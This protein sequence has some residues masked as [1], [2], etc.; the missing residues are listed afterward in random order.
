MK[1]MGMLLIPLLVLALLAGSVG[2]GGEE[3]TPTPVPTAAPTA[4]PTATPTPPPIELRVSFAYAESDVRYTTLTKI[5]DLMEEYTDGRVK[6][7]LFTNAVLFPPATEWE[8][9][10]T[11]AVD[12]SF[13]A[14]YYASTVDPANMLWYLGGGV[15]ESPEHGWAV[16]EDGR[17]TQIFADKALANGVK[18]LGI[19]PYSMRQPF[20]CTEEVIY[21]KDAAG[22]KFA[23]GGAPSPIFQYMEVVPVVMDPSEYYV[24][25]AQGTVDS[26]GPSAISMV[27][28]Q[29]LYEVADY[30]FVHPMGYFAISLWMS[31]DTWNGLPADIQ[32]IIENKVVPEALK[33]SHDYFV[34]QEEKDMAELASHLVALHETQ[35]ADA[36]A[37]AEALETNETQKTLLEKVGPEII[38]ILE[39]LRPSS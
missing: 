4:A 21:Y 27:L 18:Q 25:L 17:V 20:I 19:F 14:P 22:L 15:W 37:A 39:E 31:P 28:S 23:T 30:C 7:N 32:D 11:G 10:T 34:E 35:P 36:R 9:I 26:A 5:K 2:C 33:F 6:L 13:T 24:A 12:M 3:A 8:A 1:R 29:K 16:L 38:N